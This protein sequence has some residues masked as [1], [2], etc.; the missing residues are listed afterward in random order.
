MIVRNKILNFMIQRIKV[1][2]E[3]AF[4]FYFCVLVTRL[5]I[6]NSYLWWR[7]AKPKW[8]ASFSFTALWLECGYVIDG[9][10]SVKEAFVRLLYAIILLVGWFVSVHC[11]LV[12]PKRTVFVCLRSS[13]AKIWSYSLSFL[14][15]KR[16]I[17][18]SVS[19]PVRWWV[20]CFRSWVNRSVWWGKWRSKSVK[21]C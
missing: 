3:N 15:N 10:T 2:Q 12:K 17:L 5:S 4:T 7:Q 16:S 18:F 1:I 20:W 8:T 13:L 21:S 6:F 9:F 11:R 19:E 14:L